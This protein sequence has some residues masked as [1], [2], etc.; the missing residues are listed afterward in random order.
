MEANTAGGLEQN[1]QQTNGTYKSKW[2]VSLK[3]SYSLAIRY[4]WYCNILIDSKDT[5]LALGQKF[6]MIDIEQGYTTASTSITQWSVFIHIRHGHG[7]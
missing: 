3:I 7:S 1:K 5:F 2:H 4:I 6:V